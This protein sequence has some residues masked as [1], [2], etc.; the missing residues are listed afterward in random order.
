VK[1]KII[2]QKEQKHIDHIESYENTIKKA[3]EFKE[4]MR[5][6]NLTQTGL[7]EKIGISRVRISQYLSL[8]KLP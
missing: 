7:T 5:K 6:D 8:L 4:I 3:L 1:N 2:T